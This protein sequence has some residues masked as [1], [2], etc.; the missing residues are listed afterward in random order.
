MKK[1]ILE[2]ANCIGCGSCTQV[3][4]KFFEMGEDGKS[5]LKGAAPENEQQI[6]ELQVEDPGCARD[7]EEVCPAQVIHIEE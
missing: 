7:A 6:Q 1:I 5:T 3:C 4:P 2:R